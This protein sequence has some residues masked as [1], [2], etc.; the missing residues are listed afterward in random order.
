MVDGLAQAPLNTM[1]ETIQTLCLPLLVTGKADD[2]AMDFQKRQVW[3][4]NNDDGEG[5]RGAASAAAMRTFI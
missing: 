4:N 5:A 1:R 2:E 3:N